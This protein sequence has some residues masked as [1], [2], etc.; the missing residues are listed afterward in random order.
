MMRL[1]ELTKVLNQV[2]IKP[3]KMMMLIQDYLSIIDPH[4]EA[5]AEIKQRLIDKFGYLP[6]VVL[7]NNGVVEPVPEQDI[8]AA[9]EEELE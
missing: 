8:Q 6:R 1:K 9:F 2:P 3:T 4:P 7:V 5:Q